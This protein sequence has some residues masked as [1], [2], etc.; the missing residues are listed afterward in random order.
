MLPTEASAKKP[1]AR[2]KKVALL[3]VRESNRGQ[4]RH[5]GRFLAGLKSALTL[6]SIGSVAPRP[7]MRASRILKAGSSG[8][9]GGSAISGGLSGPGKSGD[10]TRI[11]M[12]ASIRML[13]GV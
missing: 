13:I 9:G 12:S 1:H 3:N 4:A 7:A 6:G 2:L 11:T 10:R 5:S 8:V